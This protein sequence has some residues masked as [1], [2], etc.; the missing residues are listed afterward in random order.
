MSTVLQAPITDLTVNEFGDVNT[1]IRQGKTYHDVPEYVSRELCCHISAPPSAISLLPSP[2]LPIIHLLDFPTPQITPSL[3]LSMQKQPFHT[4]EP[5]THPLSVYRSLPL[6]TASLRRFWP[7]LVRLCLM[8]RLR[9]NTGT[10]GTF[11]CHSM[12]LECG[13]LSLKQTLPRRPGKV[14]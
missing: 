11:S 6:H 8:G 12:L 4:V 2:Q 9:C 1:W 14:H 3:R 13:S 10:R 7:V 5:H